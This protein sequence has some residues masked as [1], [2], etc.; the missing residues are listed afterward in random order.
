M[1]GIALAW[2][3]SIGQAAITCVRMQDMLLHRGPDSCGSW[4]TRIGAGELAMAHRRLA[5]IDLTDAGHQPM[6]DPN[7]GN[8]IIYN[9]EVYNFRALRESLVRLGEQFRG[10]SDTEVIL[11]GFRRWGTELFNKLHGMFALAIFWKEK[12]RLILARDGLGI[13][14]LYWSQN[15]E[16]VFVSSELQALLRSG[17]IKAE[18]NRA[19]IETLLAFGSVAEPLSMVAGAKMFPAGSFVEMNLEAGPHLGT[20]NAFWTPEVN[21]VECDQ[22]VAVDQ[23]T[24][25]LGHSAKTHLESDA[26]LGIFLSGGIDSTSLVALAKRVS[27]RSLT[28]LNVSFPEITDLDESKIATQ[29]ARELGTQHVSISLS[30]SDL[31]TCLH[32]FSASMDQPTLDGL[33][34]YIVSKSAKDAGLKVVWS[35]LG[36]DELFAGYDTFRQVPTA[37]NALKYFRKVPSSWRTGLTNCLLIG[38]TKNTRLKAME[39]AGDLDDFVGFALRRRRVF[40]DSELAAGG[41]TRSESL[42]RWHLPLEFALP[43][44]CFGEDLITAMSAIELSVYMRNTLLRDADVFGMAHSIEIRVP[45]LDR[46]LVD[47]MMKIPGWMRLPRSTV[48][49]RL[50]VEAV[51]DARLDEISTLCKRGFALPYRQWMLGPFREQLDCGF[52]SLKRFEIFDSK[53]LQNFWNDGKCPPNTPW[54]RAWI[55]GMLGLWMEKHLSN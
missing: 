40:S 33:N 36:G 37:Y 16:G 20:P 26:P 51:H 5:I 35:G 46:P 41:L 4:Q 48:S 31:L 13:K 47:Y 52:K 55:L 25:I 34:T 30:D 43:P 24:R 38:Q 6:S 9:G 14:P 53:W 11:A 10:N 44:A 18:P 15:S 1:C 39:M 45:L 42:N 27:A 2:T 21:S 19:A 3:R 22:G 23:L 32:D 49:K 12:K 7:T 17:A 8:V 29:T 28:T 54:N 50:L